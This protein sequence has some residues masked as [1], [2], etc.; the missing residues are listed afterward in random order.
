MD[1]KQPLNPSWTPPEHFMQ[2]DSKVPGIIVYAPK[3]EETHIDDLK[4]YTCP[5][6]GAN[7][8]YDVS[9]G[10]IA[11]EYC[12]YVA[13]VRAIN[14]GKGADEFE[15]TLDTVSQSK[16]GWGIER[17]VLHCESC[18]GEL[19]LGPGDITSTCPFCASNQVNITRSLSLIHI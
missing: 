4:S 8:A 13:P 18:G 2:V 11:C 16:R 1:E 5:S 3:P 19:S 6:C 15:F 14:V 9:A 7:I 12:G 10:G 17:Q